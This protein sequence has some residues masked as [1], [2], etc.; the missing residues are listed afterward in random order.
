MRNTVGT[1]PDG[2]V[3]HWQSQPMVRGMAVGNML[4][5][6]AILLCSLTFTSID[7]LANV[8]NLAVFSERYFYRLQKEYLYPVVH[9]NYIRQEEPM[10]EYLRGNQLLLSGDGCC[11]SPQYSAYSPMDS[12]TDLILD[13][14]LIQVSEVGS[15][16][17]MEKEEL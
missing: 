10:I 1:C 17:A 8:F 2:H 11:D 16:V 6:A 15:S 5:S 13:Y 4:S 9:I 14:S 12:A 7:N 3:L